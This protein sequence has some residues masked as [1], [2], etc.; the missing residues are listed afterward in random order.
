MTAA[1]WVKFIFLFKNKP[2]LLQKDQPTA[3]SS[4]PFL[5]IW[6]IFFLKKLHEISDVFVRYVNVFTQFKIII[7]TFIIIHPATLTSCLWALRRSLQSIL[8]REGLLEV[9]PGARD[10]FGD[11]CL[12][13]LKIICWALSHG[14]PHLAHFLC[15]K[16]YDDLYCGCFCALC[17][18]LWM[19]LLAC[20][21]Y[22]ECPMALA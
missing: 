14:R 17:F 8:I 19:V 6:L 5:S 18:T 7:I 3:F 15:I 13:W 20:E 16:F 22:P 11:V 12:V 2:S 4:L 1:G 21:P 10:I 9:V